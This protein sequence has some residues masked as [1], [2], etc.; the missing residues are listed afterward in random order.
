[1]KLLTVFVACI[2]VYYVNGY[3]IFPLPGQSA[4]VNPKFG[5][6]DTR[7]LSSVQSVTATKVA[8]FLSALPP[9]P[10]TSYK[11]SRVPEEPNASSPT[12][13][14]AL[15]SSYQT[16]KAPEVLI[17]PTPSTISSY[18]STSRE[19]KPSSSVQNL[20]S[21]SRTVAVVNPLATDLLPP[22][23]SSIPTTKPEPLSPI[24]PEIEAPSK[25]LLPPKLS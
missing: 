25:D 10:S 2:S 20:Q 18:A 11:T 9:L 8:P 7:P 4:A 22:Q 12:T 16:T 14:K 23:G 3:R 17:A 15:L 13:P 5:R 1:M 24:K 19:T 21:P 6:I